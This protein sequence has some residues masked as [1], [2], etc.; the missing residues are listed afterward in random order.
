VIKPVMHENG[1][2]HM[3]TFSS[4]AGIPVSAGDRL[5]LTATY[6]NSLPHT[7]VMGIM[8]LFLAPAAP[9]SPGRC[10][11]GPAL[12][13][14]PDSHPAAPP[15]V[16]LPLLKQ[17]TGPLKSVFSTWMGDYAYGAERIA[18]KA[19]SK[20]KWTFAGPSRHD[21]TLAS[22]PV[23]FASPSRSRGTFSF[24]FT[25]PGVYKLYCSLHPTQ[26]TQIVTV[27]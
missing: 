23:G 5:R 26:M 2:K 11:A 20:F 24:R 27:R 18:L 3:T 13:A 21:V 25:R 1:P 12:P 4:A 8:I 17:P 7:R 19:G 6:D 15:R 14:D 16:R 9:A 22:G 10:V